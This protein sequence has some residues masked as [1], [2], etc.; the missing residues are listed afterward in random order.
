MEILYLKRII[1]LLA[2]VLIIQ[3]TY[4]Q[5]N[6]P[7][8]HPDINYIGRWDKSNDNEYHSYW[9]GAYVKIKFTGTSL[10]MNLNKNATL[11]VSI[12]G[13]E[14]VQIAA[15]TGIVDI[16]SEPLKEGTHVAII[17]AQKRN[18]EIVTS[19]FVLDEGANTLALPQSEI[20]EYIGN[21]ITSAD[22][23]SKDYLSAYAWHV[24]RMLPYTEHTQIAMPGITLVDGYSYYP[25]W[26]AAPQRGMEIQYFCLK[27]PNL[28]FETKWDFLNYTPKIIVI[29]LGTNDAALNVPLDLFKSN[30]TEFI[31]KVRKEHA[32]SEIFIMRPFN[33][34]YA[35]ETEELV[36]ELNNEGDSK[37]HFI[38]TE[39]W[40]TDE[41]FYKERYPSD[42]LHP[43]DDGHYKIAQNLA[44][45]L[46]PYLTAPVAVIELSEITPFDST[47]VGQ[48]SEAQVLKITNTGNRDL[49]ISEIELPDGFDCDWKSGLI[50]VG[51]NQEINMVFKPTEL[52]NYTGTLNII[53]DADE[54]NN[55]IAVSGIA[56]TRTSV[57]LIQNTHG[58]K[59]YPNPVSSI[60]TV[61]L[62]GDMNTQLSIYNDTGQRVYS[63]N[64]VNSHEIIDLTEF[65]K[66]IY[67]IQ[68]IS[69]GRKSTG[70]FL[71]E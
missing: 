50:E 32:L 5:T 18:D 36:N 47:E 45:I 1:V 19:G 65:E 29:N 12:D 44:P 55:T 67:L 4:S 20:I 71:L 60:L 10:K 58:L 8:N 62:M 35:I 43:S 7:V 54:G 33:K 13:G 28:D 39:G 56:F 31:K 17:A 61:E 6:I 57:E 49:S 69:E 66:G 23:T 38:D 41:D 34:S 68:V 48:T 3:Y 15:K 46:E 9:G 40:L 30:Y 42:K 21:S 2:F 24:G 16:N 53:S 52:K 59:F 27:Q 11:I 64:T 63:V 25:G 51:Q 26:G 37:I 22:M 70:K 14:D